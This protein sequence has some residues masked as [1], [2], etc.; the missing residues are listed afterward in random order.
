M[1][2]L[3]TCG[4]SA[5]K[6]IHMPG[7]QVENRQMYSIFLQKKYLIH[8]DLENSGNNHGYS[9]H[10]I[11]LKYCSI[12]ISQ[13]DRT[14]PPRPE[15][16]SCLYV[17]GE[18]AWRMACKHLT[19]FHQAFFSLCQGQRL[20]TSMQCLTLGTLLCSIIQWLL[21]KSCGE[22]SSVTDGHP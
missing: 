6:Q 9:Y 11:S 21:L 5:W 18:V 20:K 12:P 19:M 22:H 7:T 17:A 1:H 4:S 2:A 10:T 15:I 16:Q 13:T 3:Y 14:N 8:E